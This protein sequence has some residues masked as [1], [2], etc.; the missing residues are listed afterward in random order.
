LSRALDDAFAG[1][2]LA[3]DALGGDRGGDG[4]VVGAVRTVPDACGA[5]VRT[6][7]GLGG[8]LGRGVGPTLPGL[9]GA[10]GYGVGRTVPGLDPG[11][12]VGRVAGGGTGG[13][14]PR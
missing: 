8:A 5:G 2:S 6:L 9:G 4:F 14:R 7:P 13:R 12:G 10:L 3:E 11:V 1:A